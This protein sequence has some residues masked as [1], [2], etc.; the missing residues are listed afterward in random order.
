MNANVELPERETALS[1]LSCFGIILM[2][3]LA[4]VVVW[5]WTAPGLHLFL[6]LGTYLLLGGFALWQLIRAAQM[7]S[8]V[9]RLGTVG[10]VVGLTAILFRGLSPKAGCI[11]PAGCVS[12][13]TLQPFPFALGM[14]IT[15][16]S[17]FLDIRNR[18]NLFGRR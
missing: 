12:G 11:E 10:V 17:L 15:S 18:S 2:P 16:F 14:M 6:I 1:L 9:R 8:W 4:Y 13:L 5:E 3:I 7:D